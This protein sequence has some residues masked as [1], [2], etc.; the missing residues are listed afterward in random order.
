MYKYTQSNYGGIVIKNSYLH[1]VIT[2]YE[3]NSVYMW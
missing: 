2:C 1:I 3:N